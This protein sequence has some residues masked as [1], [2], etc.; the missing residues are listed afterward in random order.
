MRRRLNMFLVVTMLVLGCAE[1]AHASSFA[2][3]VVGTGKP[4]ILIPGLSCSG[5]V[6]DATVEHFKHR[7]QM[8]VLTLAGFA[9]QPAIASPMLDTVRQELIEYIRL[10]RLERPVIV[11]HSLGG[12]IAYWVAATAPDVAGP[13]IAIDGMPYLAD[14][15]KPGAT[16]QTVRPK[17]ELLKKQMSSLTREQFVAQNRAFLTHTIT[18][19]EDVEHVAKDSERSSPVAVAQA[20]YELMTTDL[21]DVAASITSPTLLIASG[22]SVKNAAEKEELLAHYERQLAKIQNH[23]VV[24]VEHARHFAMLDAPKF[25]YAEMESF[26]AVRRRER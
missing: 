18:A 24:L 22:A 10:H 20:M 1:R 4:M 13:I 14:L 8:H 3:R 7:Y 25:V 17:A 21:R 5:A 2:V 12:F 26:L 15:F 9:G 16:V 6:W 19:P 23:R 11:G